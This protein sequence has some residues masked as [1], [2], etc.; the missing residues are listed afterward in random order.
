[1]RELLSFE[2]ARLF[3]AF[4]TPPALLADGEQKDRLPRADFVNSTIKLSDFTGRE[5]RRMRG[6]THADEP[7]DAGVIHKPF[8]YSYTQPTNKNITRVIISRNKQ[9]KARQ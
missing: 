3:I 4:E 9:H 5:E 6:Y 2:M 8:S 7:N 1:M